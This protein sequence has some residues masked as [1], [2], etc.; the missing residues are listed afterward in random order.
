MESIIE[1]EFKV[2]ERVFWRIKEL[3]NGMPV[4]SWGTGTIKQIND[5]VIC[6]LKEDGKEWCFTRDMLFRSYELG[7]G[8]RYVR[9]KFTP[10]ELWEQERSREE[11]AER[12]ALERKRKREEAAEKKQRIQFVSYD[13]DYPNLC[14]GKLT[15]KIDGKKKTFYYDRG[16]ADYPSFWYSG[17]GWWI[18]NDGMDHVREGDWEFHWEKEHECFSEEDKL[19]ME[20][21]FQ[22][23][24]PNGC[25]GGCI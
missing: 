4:D 9:P 7:E 10:Q 11:K 19:R 24:V 14:S 8:K 16:K 6:V 20:K 3:V 13:G 22:K 2:G 18:D 5:N 1:I 23:H 15:L 21:L 12:E 25:C 17:G